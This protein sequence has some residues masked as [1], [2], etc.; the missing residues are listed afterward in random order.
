MVNL[1]LFSTILFI[2]IPVLTGLTSVSVVA[3]QTTLQTSTANMT[4]SDTANMTGSDTANMTGSD[5]NQ[6]MEPEAGMISRKD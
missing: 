6:E 5:N 2:A 3:Q 1:I 4:G